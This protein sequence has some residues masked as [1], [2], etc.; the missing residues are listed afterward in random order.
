[1]TPSK[2]WKE[3]VAANEDERFLAYAQ[4]FRTRQR[5]IAGSAK[6]RRAL[7][8]KGLGVAATFTVLPDLPAHARAGMFA[9]PRDYRAYVR[10][11]NGSGR[12]QHDKVPDVRGI[13]IK[14][15]G[16]PGKKIIPGLENAST[17]DFLLVRS[18]SIPF[19]DARE[20]TEIATA[21]S[22]P[23]ILFR[24]VTRIGPARGLALL[25]KLKSGLSEP[26][27]SLA[28]TQFF[29]PVPIRAGDYAA[30]FDLVPH[31]QHDGKS[32]DRVAPDHLVEELSGRLRGGPISYDFRMQYFVD[33][34][35]TPIEDPT[36]EWSDAVAPPVTVA[37]LVIPQTDLS[38][39]AAKQ[40]QALVDQLAFDPW[41]AL[42]EHR[43]LGELM[44]AR[45][46]AYRLSGE[47]RGVAPEPEA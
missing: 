8:A 25:K 2:D 46:H 47:E 14:V 29:S 4:R 20:L 11:S 18:R 36:V 7:H 44:R 3:N 39:D 26:M 16:V 34:K 35:Q 42:V 10:F 27:T 31:A 15:I 43:P 23:A 33:E 41:H 6:A 13:A 38:A 19:R 28:T 5:Q 12:S 24:A 22:M 1:M 40:V 21:G 30:R 32:L 17:Q 45:N 37:R 9:Q